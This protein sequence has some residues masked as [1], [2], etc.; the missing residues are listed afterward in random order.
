M[1][2]NSNTATIIIE[3]I[4]LNLI[5]IPPTAD[6]SAVSISWESVENADGYVIYKQNGNDKWAAIEDT[7]VLNY[8]D[9]D[10]KSETVYSY[11]VVPYRIISGEKVYGNYLYNGIELTA[12]E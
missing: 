12:S 7:T 10:V 4:C 6:A 1:T 11:T 9:Y 3:I 5:K 2:V 8:Q